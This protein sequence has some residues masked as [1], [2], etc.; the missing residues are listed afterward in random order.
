MMLC[1]EIKLDLHNHAFNNLHNNNRWQQILY[2]ITHIESSHLIII[3]SIKLCYH[4][5]QWEI[6][7]KF[8]S[9]HV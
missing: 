8:H 6:S 2:N 5:V 3:L 9:F 1:N 4:T 7:S